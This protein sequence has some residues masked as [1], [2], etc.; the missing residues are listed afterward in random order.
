MN[1]AVQAP[2]SVSAR[3]RRT[4]EQLLTALGRHD[5]LSRAELAQLTGL[6]RS[7]VGACVTDLVEQGLVDEC[8][9]TDRQ[10]AGPGRPAAVV[11]LRRGAGIVL[12]LDFGHTHVTA[13]VADTEGRILAER[14]E[15]LDVDGQPQEAMAAGARLAAAA[16]QASGHTMDEVLG[17]AAGV[18]GPIDVRTS[19]V[20][21]PTILASWIGLDPEAELAARLGRPVAV[22]NDADMGAWA[23]HL[24]GA[25]RGIDDLV[26]VKASHGIGAGLILGGRP[27]RGATGIAGEIGHTQ[28]PGAINWCRCG[29]QGCLETVVS[30]GAVYRRLAHVLGWPAGSAGVMAAGGAVGSSLASGA[31]SASGAVAAIGGNA[32]GPMASGAATSGVAVTMI[33]NAGNA[34]SA[35]GA[36][37]SGTTASSAGVAITGNTGNAGSAGGAIASGTTASNA[38]VA[39]ADDTSNTGNAGGTVSSGTA[40][41]GAG[42]AMT[43][44]AAG[45]AGGALSSSTAAGSAGMAMADDSGNAG[46]AMFSGA[47]ASGT[48]AAMTGGAADNAGGAGRAIASSTTAGGA[49]AAVASRAGGTV[50]SSTG[51]AVASDMGA[52]GGEVTSSAPGTMTRNT[53]GAGA[54]AADASGT[55]ADDA[56]GEL[57]GGVGESDSTA[58][59]GAS[60]GSSAALGGPPSGDDA[61]IGTAGNGLGTAVGYAIGGAGAATGSSGTGLPTMAELATSPA[62]ARVLTDAGRTI[63]RVLADLIN[64]LNPAAVVLGGELGSAGDPLVAGVRE[65]IDRHAGQAGA[66]AVQVLAGRLGARAEL[67]GAIATAIRQTAGANTNETR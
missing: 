2:A 7:A 39:M 34:G 35:A 50:P 3:R 60:R 43:G 59:G 30:I 22:A 38:G 23:E 63:G 47:A 46:G 16:L 65:S 9:V 31:D 61:A 15:T 28:L 51:G 12:G 62:A 17:A 41:S 54:L 55:V 67:L 48:G 8:P 57:A 58:T 20:R 24:Y 1:P 26:Y 13:A 33:D 45:S 40:A 4:R 5:A 29:N 14:G 36:I 66:G 19:V 11:R 37:A 25:G 10:A 18:P 53:G 49:S 44:G 6:S 52:A 56:G 21:E 27:Y 42:G 32:G 64:C